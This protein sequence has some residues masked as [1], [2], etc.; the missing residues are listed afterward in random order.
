[1][2]TLQ[3]Y[4]KKPNEKISDALSSLIF[5]YPSPLTDSMKEMCLRMFPDNIAPESFF[6]GRITQNYRLSAEVLST[7]DSVQAIKLISEILHKLASDTE[8]FARE[9]E[10]KALELIPR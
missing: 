8:V 3:K 9:W 2:A 4:E 10:K 7:C 5:G 1:M 6:N